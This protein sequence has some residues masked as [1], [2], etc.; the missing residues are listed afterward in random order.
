MVEGLLSLVHLDPPPR[1]VGHAHGPGPIDRHRSGC[2]RSRYGHGPRRCR[3]RS[4]YPAPMAPV[5]TTFATT[6]VCYRTLTADVTGPWATT[7]A[8]VTGCQAQHGYHR[9]TGIQATAMAAATDE[10]P[11]SGLGTGAERRG[12]PSAGVVGGTSRVRP[13]SKVTS[14]LATA[15]CRARRHL[16]PAPFSHARHISRWRSPRC[17]HRRR[18]NRCRRGRAQLG[19][20]VAVRLRAPVVIDD[21]STARS[22]PAHGFGTLRQPS[23]G[24]R[25]TT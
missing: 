5:T 11:L 9:L 24:R 17:R 1:V 15:N 20:V 21:R 22:T 25:A 19:D 6:H 8:A 12:G 13:P 4:S 23:G 16:S 3:S 14:P 10:G 2:Q 18:L 7:Q